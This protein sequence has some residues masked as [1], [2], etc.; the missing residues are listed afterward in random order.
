MFTKILIATAVAPSTASGA[1]AMTK[2]QHS[3][4][5]GNDVY[6]TSG[7]Y[8]GSDPDAK[9]RAQLMQDPSQSS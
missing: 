4:N 9:I 6:T 2:K 3:L 8:I 1:F 7:R 5:V